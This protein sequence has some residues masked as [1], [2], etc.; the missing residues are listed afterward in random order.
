MAKV[1]IVDDDQQILDVVAEALLQENYVVETTLFGEDA[2][3][4]MLTSR[5]DVVV[6]ELNLPDLSGFDV[7]KRFRDRGLSTP[8]IMLTGKTGVEDRVSGRSDGYW[9][10]NSTRSTRTDADGRLMRVSQD[11]VTARGLTG[12]TFEA[13]GTATKMVGNL[14]GKLNEDGTSFNIGKLRLNF[15]P[16]G[17]GRLF[18]QINDDDGN[19]SEN[20]GEQ[21]VRV[22][23]TQP[24]S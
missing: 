23:L 18:L 13:D 9:S 21:T 4:C 19:L 15:S 17:T 10:T 7:C 5:F 11:Y 3:E 6:L 1:L 24:G 22:V 14:L 2:L 12:W 8:I 20:N 16:P